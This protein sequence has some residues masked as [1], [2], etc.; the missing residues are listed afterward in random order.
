MDEKATLEMFGLWKKERL[1]SF[2]RARGLP[3]TGTIAELRA[4]AY[5]A[6]IMAVPVKQTAEEEKATRYV[7]LL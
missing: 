7:F 4:L 3:T 2:L 6:S 5:S 1:I